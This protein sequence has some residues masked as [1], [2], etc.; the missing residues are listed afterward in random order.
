M[1]R[2]YEYDVV[3]TDILSVGEL[4]VSRDVFGVDMRVTRCIIY[5]DSTNEELARGFGGSQDD[6]KYDAEGNL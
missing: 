2:R 5:D 4:S 3:D 6:A 1:G